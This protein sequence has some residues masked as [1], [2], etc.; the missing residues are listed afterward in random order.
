MSTLQNNAIDHAISIHAPRVGSDEK[1]YS[2][3]HRRFISIHAPR[4]GSDVGVELLSSNHRNF[5][6]RS[7]RGER[8]S[9]VGGFD[10]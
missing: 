8:L 5:N 7:P 10:E 3:N 2:D 9:A 6:P 1:D 4:V